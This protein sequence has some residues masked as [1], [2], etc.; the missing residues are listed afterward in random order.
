MT[1]EFQS[2]LD[3]DEV[4]HHVANATRLAT[5]AIANDRLY[6]APRTGMTGIT[7]NPL[8]N[9]SQLCIYRTIKVKQCRLRLTRLRCDN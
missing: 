2:R 9:L 4:F 1:L 6:D 5:A 8:A 3:S 7:R